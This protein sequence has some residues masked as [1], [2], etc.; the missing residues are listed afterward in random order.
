MWCG[1]ICC[2]FSTCRITRFMAPHFLLWNLHHPPLS[3]KHL[4]LTL[5]ADHLAKPLLPSTPSARYT[6]ALQ[7]LQSDTNV[8]M[9]L[10]GA[11]NEFASAT[12]SDVDTLVADLKPYLEVVFSC[13][14]GR[15]MFGSD[16]PVCNVGGP[17]GE[18]GNWG[19]WRDVVERV[20]GEGKEREGVWCEVGCEAYG[21]ES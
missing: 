7:A 18:E 14:K 9:K 12:P 3:Q 16:W 8:Y 15:V 13:F 17:R 10:S 1:N 5:L 4:R 6:A 19:L 11:F 21:I 20:V 2:V